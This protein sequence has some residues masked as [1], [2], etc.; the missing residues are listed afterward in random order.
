MSPAIATGMRRL[1]L[2]EVFNVNDLPDSQRNPGRVKVLRAMAAHDQAQIERWNAS[3][4]EDLVSSAFEDAVIA[5]CDGTGD[6]VA[7]DRAYMQSRGALPAP[8]EET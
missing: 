8:G 3:H 6:V 2:R 7:I 1:V 4:P 5:W